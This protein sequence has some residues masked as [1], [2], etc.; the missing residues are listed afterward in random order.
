[1]VGGVDS[2]NV[3]VVS[4]LRGSSFLVFNSKCFVE[5]TAVVLMERILFFPF[6]VY[7]N[8][9]FGP[10]IEGPRGSKWVIGVSVYDVVE[11]SF[12]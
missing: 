10:T 1:M 7:P 9:L 5:S 8:H 4:L 6:S 3:Y 12:L 11:E 2:I